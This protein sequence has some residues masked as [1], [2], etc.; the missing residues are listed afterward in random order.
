MISLDQMSLNHSSAKAPSESVI[1]S[2]FET[3]L[4]SNACLRVHGDGSEVEG[5]AEGVLGVKLV[6]AQ[7]VEQAEKRISCHVVLLV[8]S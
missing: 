3:S 6:L 4:V 2:K 5:D 8:I 1:S 7:H